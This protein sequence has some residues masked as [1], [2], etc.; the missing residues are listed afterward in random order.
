MTVWFA[1]DRALSSTAG[2]IS[3]RN[4]PQIWFCSTAHGQASA[5]TSGC[6]ME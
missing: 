6:V 3:R 5:N 1:F 4:Q 2:V